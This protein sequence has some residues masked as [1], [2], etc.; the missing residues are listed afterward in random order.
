MQPYNIVQAECYSYLFGIADYECCFALFGH[1][2]FC[3]R[4]H[5]IFHLELLDLI[6]FSPLCMLFKLMLDM[7][8]TVWT[9]IRLLKFDAWVQ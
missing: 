9:L 6:V 7:L 3:W 4:Q 8:P 5:L 2:S 1:V